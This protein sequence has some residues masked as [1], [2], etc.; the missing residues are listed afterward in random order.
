MTGVYNEV[1]TTKIIAVEQLAQLF[2]IMSDEHS[3]AP[4]IQAIDVQ[5]Q[6][7]STDF[8]ADMRL[9]TKIATILRAP[10]HLLIVQAKED[11][12]EAAHQSTTICVYTGA[13]G[14]RQIN[15]LDPPWVR[16]I[17]PRE[18]YSIFGVSPV[19]RVFQKGTNDPEDTLE[20]LAEQDGVKIT[21]GALSLAFSDALRGVE[22]NAGSMVFEGKVVAL[23]IWKVGYEE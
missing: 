8:Q 1:A 15:N 10:D 20:I 19:H 3:L 13:L 4:N 7:G 21:A 2:L 18:K 5:L 6:P 11:I 14:E 12:S 9:I 16:F 17:R 23:E 22:I